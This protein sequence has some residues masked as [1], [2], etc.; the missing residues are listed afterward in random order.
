M[1][2]FSVFI[3][4][5]FLLCSLTQ[6]GWRWDKQKFQ[7][8][9]APQVEQRITSDSYCFDTGWEF[10]LFGS[11]FWPEDTRLDEE[12]GGGVGLAYYFGHNLGIEGNYRL[13]SGSQAEQVGQLNLVYRFPLGGE[14]CS[15][16]APYVF[17]GPGVVSSGTTEM[18]W[19]VGGGLD[20]RFESWGC[21]GMFADYSY[22]F[23]E[24]G[25]PDFSMVRFGFRFPF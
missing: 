24:Q 20:F 21:V 25:L 8:A 18:L 10:S 3:A 17:G 1:K 19:N 13:H 2:G 7:S 16:I 4:V 22:N 6:A 5:S 23:V 11:G 12:I 14:C 15:T 9:K